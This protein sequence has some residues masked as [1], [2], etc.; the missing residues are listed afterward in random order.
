MV[1]QCVRIFGPYGF[2]YAVV[3]VRMTTTGLPSC[4]MQLIM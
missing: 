3:S 4:C 2:F 1:E